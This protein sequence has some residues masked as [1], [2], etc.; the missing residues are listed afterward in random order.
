MGRIVNKLSLKGD[1]ILGFVVIALM[2]ISVL[3]VYSSTGSLAFRVRGG[4]T[5]FYLLKQLFLLVGC[6]GVILLT[7]SCHYKY[8]LSF[9]SFLLLASFGFLL[10]AKVMGATLNDTDRW[11]KI[12]GISFQPSEFAKLA[13]IIFCARAIAFEQTE[14]GCDDNVLLRLLWIIPVL[15]MIFMENFSTSAL[16]GGICLFMLFVGR[17]SMRTFM[18]IIGGLVVAVALLIGVLFLMPEKQL[19]KVG[20]LLTVKSR[21]EAFFVP[22]KANKDDSYQS[23]QAKIAVARGGLFKVAPGTSVQRNFLPHP[24]SDFIFAIIVEEYGLGG[25][26]IVMLLY[27]IILY[28]VGVI[29]RRCTRMFPAMLVTGLGLCIVLQALINMG[30]CVGLFPVTGQPLPLVSMG[31]TSLLFTSAAFGM[32]LSVSHTFSEEGELEAKEKVKMAGQ[33]VNEEM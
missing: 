19:G 26:G 10:L 22:S 16:L 29:V 14:K 13:V 32:I 8:L 7:Q 31:G 9:A 18:K 5:S 20:R 33:E 4:D 27:L 23:D 28:R 3:V 17:L 25:A 12:F 15:G 2:L 11:I 24:Y 30:V 1:R 21:L 6:Y